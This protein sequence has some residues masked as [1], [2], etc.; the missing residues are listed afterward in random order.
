MAE[1]AVKPEAGQEPEKTKPPKTFAS[2]LTEHRQAGLHNELTEALSEVAAA[3][4][5][6]G[7]AGSIAVKLTIEPVEDD[8]RAVTVKDQW[9]HKV[10][11]AT[12]KPSRFFA[13]TEGQLS[14]RDPRQPELPLREA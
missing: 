7:K 13:T 12:P 3:V 4:L 1:P 10:P 5:E 11:K 9:T 8:D 2:F 14:R 6:H